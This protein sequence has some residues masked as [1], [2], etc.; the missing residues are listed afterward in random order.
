M[1]QPQI[2]HQQGQNIAT[3]PNQIKSTECETKWNKWTERDRRS[4]EERYVLIA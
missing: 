3:K 1:S 2:V 4:A